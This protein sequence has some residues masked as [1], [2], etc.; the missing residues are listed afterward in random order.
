MN[1]TRIALTGLDGEVLG[2][3]CLD[4]LVGHCVSECLQLLRWAPIVLKHDKQSL[5]PGEGASSVFLSV[6]TV[7]SIECSLVLF[8]AICP[9]SN[10]E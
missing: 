7:V 2:R 6:E 9:T 4:V 8:V 1:S 5:C 10:P 3:D